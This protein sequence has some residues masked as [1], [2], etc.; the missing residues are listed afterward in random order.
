MYMYVCMYVCILLCLSHSPHIY[1]W[2][3]LVSFATGRVKR[4]DPVPGGTQY[5]PGPAGIFFC[6]R[7]NNS[8]VGQVIERTR[9]CHM[10]IY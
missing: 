8:W 4:M 2:R 7:F 3:C 9:C 5:P 1:I 10:C 6:T